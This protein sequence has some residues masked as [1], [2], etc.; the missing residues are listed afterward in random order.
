MF[1]TTLPMI[2]GI[3]SSGSNPFTIVT[4]V[5]TGRS[6]RAPESQTPVSQPD[7]QPAELQEPSGDEASLSREFTLLDVASRQ[8]ARILPQIEMATSPVD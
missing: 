1:V 6:G 5:Q 8:F 7:V 2:S 4:K 3:S